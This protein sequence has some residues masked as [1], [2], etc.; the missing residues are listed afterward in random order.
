MS[1]QAGLSKLYHCV[2]ALRYHLVVVTKYRRQCLTA[3]MLERL[4]AI[5]AA[6]CKG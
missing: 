6:R 4:R 2:Y 5:A 3:A 1:A